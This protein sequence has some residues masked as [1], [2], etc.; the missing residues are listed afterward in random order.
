MLNATL[1]S[2]SKRMALLQA[3]H[4]LSCA[5][6]E[7]AVVVGLQHAEHGHIKAAR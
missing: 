3:E 7:R 1:T 2:L 6:G 5:T 4:R